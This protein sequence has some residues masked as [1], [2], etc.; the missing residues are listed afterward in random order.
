MKN[1]LSSLQCSIAENEHS[2]NLMT[3]WNFT[4]S[5]LRIKHIQCEVLGEELQNLEEK[6]EIL[7][8]DL[9]NR[10]DDQPTSE[11]RAIIR[12]LRTEVESKDE[13][14][15]TKSKHCDQLK[16]SLEQKN[17]E[18]GQ[19]RNQLE[20]L[21]HDLQEQQQAKSGSSW[22]A[23]FESEQHQQLEENRNKLKEKNSQI[24]QLLD[25]LYDSDRIN[26]DL[27]E[28]VSK[29]RVENAKLNNDI[30]ITESKCDMFMEQMKELKQLN[31]SFVLERETRD[32][33]FKLL[34][35]KFLE[36]SD[37]QVDNIVT[38]GNKSD[39][40]LEQL[41]QE[42]KRLNILL[43]VKETEINELRL[44]LQIDGGKKVP[45]EE[46]DQRKLQIERLEQELSIMT[47]YGQSGSGETLNQGLIR[48]FRKRI[49][50]LKKHNQ[51]LVEKIIALEEE[52]K[53]RDQDVEK[54]RQRTLSLVDGDGK[55]RNLVE[56]NSVL[57][58][59]IRF[60]DDKINFLIE[61]LNKHQM[62][63]LLPKTS[64]GL[65]SKEQAN[66]KEVT[67][68]M[69]HVIA[70]GVERDVLQKQL[71]ALKCHL[72]S[73]QNENLEL[74]LGMKEILDGIRQS[75]A[76]SD[77]VIEC[78]SLE[79][80]CIL[81]ENRF[82]YSDISTEDR[83]DLTKFVLL[84]S[85][86]DLVRGQNEQLRTEIKQL[87][88]DYLS[89]IDEYTTDIL[90]NWTTISTETQPD[91]S[92][93]VLDSS[94]QTIDVENSEDSTSNQNLSDELQP[95][96]TP[97]QTEIFQTRESSRRIAVR[98]QSKHRKPRKLKNKLTK[99]ST[100]TLIEI[101]TKDN[102]TQTESVPGS[103]EINEEKEA[104]NE[105]NQIKLVVETVDDETQTE[106]IQ[107]IESSDTLSTS[108]EIDYVSIS[109]AQTQTQMP[110]MVDQSSQTIEEPKNQVK[111][112]P[113][114]ASSDNQPCFQ[115]NKYKLMLSS[116][117]GLIE[118]E[119]Y[120]TRLNLQQHQEKIV[121]LK[122][123]LQVRHIHFRQTLIIPLITVGQ[124]RIQTG[125]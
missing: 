10:S 60:R 79:R 98:R 123:N 85:E 43:E 34:E 120:Q 110:S 71:D 113:V 24:E 102:F 52:A 51:Q 29:L 59:M 124:K 18:I 45:C 78:P 7:T 73:V 37:K 115:C 47:N 25:K 109:E 116:V 14:L 17:R 20:A 121:T 2:D 12:K 72:E 103:N 32:K 84:K 55:L 69:D 54:Q 68:L 58:K 90:E 15:E 118:K 65:A 21:H 4:R 82:V 95:E 97:Q 89:V 105:T 9:G 101:Q 106:P 8:D 56:E 107:D 19:L 99:T 96:V 61:Q 35:Q 112:P 48:Q 49:R 64:N 63:G 66:E 44:N 11:T 62:M 40:V 111:D 22:S 3:I 117:R 74:Q 41:S 100:T 125:H 42:I 88:I 77:T 122:E 6:F 86:L 36:Q 26:L 108:N 28:Q 5:L 57:S 67:N 38:S 46:L 50:K 114:V 70:L 30:R 13:E 93:T 80:V 119:R 27:A 33:E 91:I 104:T 92:L 81:L 23:S 83:I 53:L 39:D 75:D 87:R 76:N 31:E 1:L 94:M 16:D